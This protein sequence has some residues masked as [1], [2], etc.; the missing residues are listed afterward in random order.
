MDIIIVQTKEDMERI[1]LWV[2]DYLCN[3][4]EL[5]N[6]IEFRSPFQKG[7]IQFPFDGCRITFQC[8]GDTHVRFEVHTILKFLNG[9]DWLAELKDRVKGEELLLGGFRMNTETQEVSEKWF[10][11]SGV[12]AKLAAEY[13]RKGNL[14]PMFGIRWSALMLLA[15]YYR[16]EFKKRRQNA[17]TFINGKNQMHKRKKGK[18]A[19]PLHTRTYVI[20]G[21][22]T[23]A[24][25]KLKRT[26]TKPDHEFGVR[27]HY[28]RYKSGKTVWI[29]PHIRYKGRTPGK[30][31]T[32]IARIENGEN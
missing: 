27:G 25:P 11:M 31:N 9:G 26:Y 14:F 30:G 29:P 8:E 32:Y 23:E 22:F 21:D 2:H 15:V 1:L 20:G 5:G 28:R 10:H 12:F 24:L 19:K 4:P 17:F 7:E 16:P 6:S 18:R 13:E 3:T